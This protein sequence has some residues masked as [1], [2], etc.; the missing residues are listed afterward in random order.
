MTNYVNHGKKIEHAPVELARPQAANALVSLAVRRTALNHPRRTS[1][2][3]CPPPGN[4]RS[5]R[6]IWN[7]PS[8]DRHRLRTVA[9][10]RL[11]RGQSRIGHLRQPNS[12]RRTIASAPGKIAGANSKAQHYPIRLC[13]TSATA[14]SIGV[15]P[16]AGISRQPTGARCFSHRP[17]GAG[18]DAAPAPGFDSFIGGRRSARLS[19][20]TRGGSGISEHV[21]RREVH[22]RSGVD[23]LRR[24]TG[25]G[26]RRPLTARRRR[27]G[28]DGGTGIS[29]R[30]SRVSSCGRENL[31][32]TRRFRRLEPRSRTPTLEAT[33]SP[34]DLRHSRTPVPS[35]RNHEP[36]PALVATGMGAAL[37]HDYF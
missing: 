13:A 2:P 1:A 5:R 18:G 16:C 29:R 28:V 3:W 19:T 21:S 33:A 12:S 23:H 6:A 20:L 7:F 37:A 24:T 8:H 4:A 14:A 35:R 27:S 36:A 11:R 34:A 22:G 32:R 9:I 31:S 30:G 25:A 15:P 17:L 26:S 10:R